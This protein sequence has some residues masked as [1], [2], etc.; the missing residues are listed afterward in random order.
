MDSRSNAHRSQ[1]IL[2]P[3]KTM[4]KSKKH[5]N[6]Q[7]VLTEHR[8]GLPWA[9]L[10]EATCGA[11]LLPRRALAQ[12]GVLILM[13]NGKPVQVQQTMGHGF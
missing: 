9:G 3:E 2:H 13:S 1:E 12:V 11:G 5:G 6:R 10:P 7:Y 4:D 8:W